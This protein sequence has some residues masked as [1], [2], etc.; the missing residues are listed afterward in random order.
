M[1]KKIEEKYQQL[2][3]VEHVLLRPGMWVGSIKDEERSCF[4]YDIDEEKMIIKDIVYAPAMLKLFD[5]VLSNSCDEYRRKDNMGLNKITIKINKKE[6]EISVIDNGGIPIVKHKEAKMY[7]PEFIF[8]QLRTSSNYDDTED[9]NVIGTNGVGS[10][11]TNIFSKKFTV[12][13]C[14]KKNQINVSWTDNMSKKSTPNITKSKDHFTNISFILDFDRFDQKE[15]GLTDEFIE[16]LHKRC[17]DAAAANPGLKIIFECGD[18]KTEWKFNRFEDYMDLY[19]DYYDKDNVISYK[20]NKKQFWICPD[21]TIDVAFVNG[22]ECSKGTHIKAVRYP[23]GHV[24]CE[25]LK[26]KHKIEV[27]NKAVD[28]KYG[29]FGIFDISNPSYNSQTKEE[30]TTPQENFYKDGSEFNIPD[31]FLKKCQNSEIIELVVDWYKKK[32]EAEDSKTLRKLNKDASKGLKRSTKY[33]PANSKRR[34][35]RQLWIYEG[36]S[37]GRGFRVARDPQIQAAYT[38]RGVPPNALGMS[39][40]QIMQNDVFNDLVSVIGLKFGSDFDINNINFGKIVISTDADVDGDRICAL[41]LLFFSTNWPELIEKNIV[42][43]SISPIIIANKGKESR[44]YYSIEDFN[45][46]SSKLK[47]YEIKYCKGLSGLNAKETK[48]MMREPIFHYFTKDNQADHF[49]KKWF[50]KDADIRKDLMVGV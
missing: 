41:L 43:R 26:K 13:S 15:K 50:G 14:D 17:I 9:R 42:C 2:S 27:T 49:F 19:S 37:A 45:K 29:I 30:L 20:D 32:L 18:L 5:E 48:E 40:L 34:I 12:I 21:S 25:Q 33:I 28:T 16:I 10:S 3:E 46:E 39:P 23:V 47:N 11:L 36:D 22:A 38:M 7:V 35:E 6:Q 44:K 8:G 31:N 4:V 1:A 24:I